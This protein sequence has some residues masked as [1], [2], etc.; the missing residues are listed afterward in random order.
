MV[1]CRAVQTWQR[2]CVSEARR[3]RHTHG[4][5]KAGLTIG[6][7]HCLF[8]GSRAESRLGI[9][10]DRFHIPRMTVCVL[11][12]HKT[13]N[14]TNVYIPIKGVGRSISGLRGLLEPNSPMPSGDMGTCASLKIARAP[15]PIAA[16]LRETQSTLE[17]NKRHAGTRRYLRRSP[18]TR[19][20]L[21]R[22]SCAGIYNHAAAFSPRYPILN[23]ECYTCYSAL[24]PVSEVSV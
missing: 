4:Q 19:T 14:Q 11:C 7:R 2:R 8:V 17:S 12:V 9:L 16:A 18:S 22:R 5:A 3:A 1:G 24:S 13:V 10:L 15:F 21:G 20:P 6:E 23:C